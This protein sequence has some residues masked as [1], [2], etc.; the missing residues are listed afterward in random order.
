LRLKVLMAWM[1]P[2]LA[3]CLAAGAHAQEGFLTPAQSEAKAKH[4]IQEAIQALGGQAYLD[5]R[6]Q[7]CKGSV[8]FFGFHNELRNYETVIDYN[9]YPDKERTE[10]SSKRNIIDVYNGDKGWTLDRGGV[11]VMSAS[12][13]RDFQKGLQRDIN[14]LFRYRLK[15]PDLEIRYG[16]PDVVDLKQIDWVDITNPEHLTI[17]IALDSY[18][19]LPLRAV[20]ISRDAKTHERTEETELFSIYHQVQGVNT[21]FQDTRTRNGNKVYQFFIRSCTYNTGLKPDFFTRE[22]LE[23]RWKK[24]GGNKKKKKHF[25]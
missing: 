7:T 16:G 1:V 6:D 24:L 20:Y 13:I 25:F 19:H 3:L 4:L 9:L 18:S 8:A 5:V 17:R 23:E 12:N 11:S 10:Y 2:A 22:S 14:Q 21:P 15:N